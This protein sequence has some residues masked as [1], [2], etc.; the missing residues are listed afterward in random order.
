MLKLERAKEPLDLSDYFFGHD[1][2]FGNFQFYK[3]I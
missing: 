1:S 3:N 2:G